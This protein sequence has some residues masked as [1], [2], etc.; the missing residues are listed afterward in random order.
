M[1]FQDN[2]NPFG[3]PGGANPN[4]AQPYTGG[5]SYAAQLAARP[6]PQQQPQQAPDQQQQA[7]SQNMA[8]NPTLAQAPQGTPPAPQ[9]TAPMPLQQFAQQDVMIP[10]PEMQLGGFGGQL[11]Q[12][13]LGSYIPSTAPTPRP[14]MNIQSGIAPPQ[15]LPIAQN[16]GVGTVEGM[17][18]VAGATY[19]PVA[20][21]EL[22]PLLMALQGQQ[23]QQ[24]AQL[25]NAGAAAQTQ[26]TGMWGGAALG[27][28]QMAYN[29][30]LQGQRVGNSLFNTLAGYA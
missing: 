7:F 8:M 5:A 2:R 9:L 3:I 20:Q 24:N 28:Q 10:F 6:Q 25:A 17:G 11:P 19:N 30:A 27:D 26:G 12:Q 29:Q 13:Q 15:N 1:A 22:A 14:D 21:Q 4:F 16:P 18:Q 23:Y